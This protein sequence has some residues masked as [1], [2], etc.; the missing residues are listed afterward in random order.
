[1]QRLANSPEIKNC[2]RAGF[3]RVGDELHV[4]CVRLAAAQG[5]ERSLLCE[6]CEGDLR[7]LR[8]HLRDSSAKSFLLA[9]A[10]AIAA[11]AAVGEFVERIYRG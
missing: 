6:H 4:E 9:A 8:K 10:V 11:I 3:P 5:S 7:V 2:K 1:M